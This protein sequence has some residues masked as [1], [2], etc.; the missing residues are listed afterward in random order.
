MVLTRKKENREEM[1]LWEDKY[2][3][4]GLV[5]RWREMKTPEEQ[6]K[7]E[8]LPTTIFN[9]KFIPKVL[10]LVWPAYNLN[11]FDEFISG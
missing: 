1:E 7:D 4:R 2:R 6:R 3:W 11:F 8:I 5:P 9:I 10:N